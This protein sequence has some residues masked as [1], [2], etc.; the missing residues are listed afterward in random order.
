MATEHTLWAKLIDSLSGVDFAGRY[1]A[2]CHAHPAGSVAVG[3]GRTDYEAALAGTQI[4]FKYRAKGRFFQRLEKHDGGE[5]EL[6]VAFPGPFVEFV[7]SL[8]T[9]SVGIGD[10]FAGLALRVAR[11]ADPSFTPSP[12]WPAPKFTSRDELNAVVREGIALF[13]DVRQAI[14]SAGGWD[15]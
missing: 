7:L 3:L 6:N 5:I 10:T 11:R 1:Y 14:L 9:K 2:L 12:P 13:L 15:E 8:S 4:E